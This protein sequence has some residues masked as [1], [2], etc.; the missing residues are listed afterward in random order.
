MFS[1]AWYLFL[2]AAKNVYTILQQGS[3]TT[4]QSRQWFGGKKQERKT[5]P[6][7]QYLFQARDDDEHGL[8]NVTEHVPGE[9]SL[10]LPQSRDPVVIK[11]LSVQNG[12]IEYEGSHPL[13]VN[14]TPSTARLAP[15]CGRGPVIYSPPTTFRGKQLTD[16]SPVAVG[17]IALDYLK[18]LIEGAAKLA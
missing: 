3:K 4:P 11:H 5:E 17:R 12:R 2:T 1:D 7:L 13:H 15:V 10:T 18:D 8:A 9:M 16:V 14:V 6:L